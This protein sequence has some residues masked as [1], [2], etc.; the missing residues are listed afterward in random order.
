MS[1]DVQE[2]K[3]HFKGVNVIMSGISLISWPK[4]LKLLGII[5]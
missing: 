4:G 2:K 3:P 1:L 5:H